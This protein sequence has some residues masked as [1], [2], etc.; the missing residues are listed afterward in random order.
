MFLLC[1]FFFILFISPCFFFVF[2]NL[3][4]F[5][6]LIHFYLIYY[7]DS[8]IKQSI[9]HTVKIAKTAIKVE[10]LNLHMS[11]S[12]KEGG[13]MSVRDSLIFFYID[14]KFHVRVISSLARVL[15]KVEGIGFFSIWFKVRFFNF[16]T[17]KANCDWLTLILNMVH[18]NQ[19]KIVNTLIVFALRS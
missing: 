13:C 6:N 11:I 14:I 19:N 8:I 2:S 17:N 16:A 5:L 9:L 15:Q 4:V 12:V 7:Q 18:F 10:N 3:F 1:F